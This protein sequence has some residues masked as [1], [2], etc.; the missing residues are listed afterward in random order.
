[1]AT[2]RAFSRLF[3]NAR[4]SAVST[5]MSG[6]RDVVLGTVVRADGWIATIASMLPAQP[7]CRLSDAWIV[8]AQVV[9]MDPAFD[10]ALL[11]IPVTGLPAVRWAEKSPLVAGTILAAAGARKTRWGSALSAC[12]DGICPDHSRHTSGAPIR[13]QPLQ[14]VGKSTAEGYV[15][16]SLPRMRASSGETSSCRSPARRSIVR[17]MCTT[18]WTA[19]GGRAGARAPGPGRQANGPDPRTGRRA[20]DEHEGLCDFPTLF[21][22]DI[23]LSLAQCG[24]PVVDLSGKAVGM[25]MYRG[26]YGC[27][28]IPGDCVDL[29]CA[30]IDEARPLAERWIEPPAATP[31]NHGPSG[32]DQ[33]APAGP[34]RRR[35]LCDTRGR[36]QERTRTARTSTDH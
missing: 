11:K 36:G 29:P 6:S 23:P 25:T 10:L 22:H 33:T 8:D 18:A 12:L 31:A 16:D 14:V 32:R 19:T 28:A 3:A 21:E 34:R 13:P 24:G 20:A 27:M 15:V 35:R 7:K 9:G 4:P 5:W 1:M 30:R 26:A 2:A 17:R